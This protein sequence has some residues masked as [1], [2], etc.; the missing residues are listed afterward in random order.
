M[1]STGEA[2][3]ANLA[4]AIFAS[5]LL[6]LGALFIIHKMIDGEFPVGPGLVALGVDVMLIAFAVMAKSA[7]IPC[8]IFV[9]ALASMGLFPFAADQLEKADIRRIDTDQLVKAYNAYATRPDN[10]SAVFE[11]SRMLYAHGMK[12]NAIGIASAAMNSL[13][14]KA[15]P[16]SNRSL[17]DAFRSEEQTLK[18]WNREAAS[19]PKSMRPVSCQRCGHVNP[20]ECVI[21][22]KCQAPYLM[23]AAN[24]MTNRPMIYGRLLLSFAVISGVIVGAASIGLLVSGILS[25]ALVVVV[26]VVAGLFLKK[27]FLPPAF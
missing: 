19:N 1:S 17:R 12:A 6:G 7:V 13:S 11:I 3:L 22:E 23:E 27:L 4:I 25:A 24:K 15:D 18:Q 16:I 14:L 10:I 21:C 9:V 2:G 8:T 5:S 26:L 20:L